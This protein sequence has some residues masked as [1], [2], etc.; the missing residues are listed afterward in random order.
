M[1][2]VLQLMFK[3]LSQY[4]KK[5]LCFI[6]SNVLPATLTSLMSLHWFLKIHCFCETGT[7]GLGVCFVYLKIK[8]FN[9]TVTFLIFHSILHLISAD[10]D[11][12]PKR[13]FSESSE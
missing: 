13:P 5:A 4:E 3:L 12:C 6:I 2:D 8:K 7:V 9:I 10:S 11:P 1:R